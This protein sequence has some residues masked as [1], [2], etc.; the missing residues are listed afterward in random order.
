MATE[1]FKLTLAFRDLSDSPDG[2]VEEVDLGDKD[3][4]EDED[5]ELDEDGTPVADDD[6]EDE[7]ETIEE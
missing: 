1:L 5:D 4:E 3:P 2:D 7:D 6:D